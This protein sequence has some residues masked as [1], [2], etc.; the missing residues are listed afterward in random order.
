MNLF[1]W[2]AKS[3]K[4]LSDISSRVRKRKRRAGRAL[5]W[6]LQAIQVL[7]CTSRRLRSPWLTFVSYRNSQ[8]RKIMFHILSPVSPLEHE[9]ECRFS[10]RRQVSS[11]SK[12]WRSTLRHYFFQWTD[13]TRWNMGPSRFPPPFRGAVWRLFEC[14]QVGSCL[15]SSNYL[16]LRG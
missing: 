14:M 12:Y 11:L 8:F 4:S 6:S 2:Y 15:G 16:S 10:S 13:Y 1:F 3:T 7:V 9:E 5:A